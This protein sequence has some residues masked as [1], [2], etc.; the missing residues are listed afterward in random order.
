RAL[1]LDDEV[2]MPL[3]PD[4]RQAVVDL[5][6]GA[7][8]PEGDLVIDELDVAMAPRL[9]GVGE[10]DQPARLDDVEVVE[11]M[12]MLGK[13]LAGFEGQVPDPH[14]RVLEH[15]PRADLFDRSGRHRGL[16]SGARTGEPGSG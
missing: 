5:P 2:A 6:G 10:P 7:D 1:Q 16:L 13:R 12:D 3:R 9:V 14:L 8:L 4:V 15:Q 11:P